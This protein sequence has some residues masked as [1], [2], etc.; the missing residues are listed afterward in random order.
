MGGRD[1]GVTLADRL[2]DLARRTRVSDGHGREP[3]RTEG[4]D[5][6]RARP[7][8][9]RAD[10]DVGVEATRLP[11]VA[12]TQNHMS[13]SDLGRGVALD[14]LDAR[15][16]Q[17]IER[18]RKGEGRNELGA[19]RARDSDEGDVATALRE[20]L[21]D[22]EALVVSLLVDDDDRASWQTV[23]GK[24]VLRREDALRA[25]SRNRARRYDD[26]IRFELR[27]VVG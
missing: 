21:G 18:E 2:G 12:A 13:R 26:E 16:E 15:C 7:L 27:Y 8:P 23:R 10:D 11:V 9:T 19:D 3:E 1:G 5:E 24:D 22:A 4:R 25:R 14:D 6:I 17:P 20:E